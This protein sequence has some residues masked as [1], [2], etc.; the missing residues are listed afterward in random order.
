AAFMAEVWSDWIAKANIDQLELLDP[1]GPECPRG[2]RAGT[3]ARGRPR[4]SP[5]ATAPGRSSAR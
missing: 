1:F 4:S 5:P 2:G 3:L